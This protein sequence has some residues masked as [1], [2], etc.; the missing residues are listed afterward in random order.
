M[1]DLQQLLKMLEGGKVTGL[2]KGK[3]K[4]LAEFVKGRFKEIEEGQHKEYRAFYKNLESETPDQ[5]LNLELAFQ[6]F[7]IR[8]MAVMQATVEWILMFRILG[9][10][11]QLD[12]DMA[13]SSVALQSDFFDSL[14]D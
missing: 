10:E 14:G 6:L 8:R 5:P 7:M 12:D 4:E 3:A 2:P 13:K 9:D 11:V 1:L